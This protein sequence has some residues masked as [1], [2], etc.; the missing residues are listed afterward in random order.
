M[1][2]KYFMHILSLVTDNN[3]SSILEVINGP[4]REKICLW[5]FAKN[6]G[7]DQPAHL[8]S[9]ISAFVIRFL[10]SIICKLATGEISI[11]QMVSVAKYTGL[12]L[13]LSE[14]PKQGFLVTRPK[15]Y[16]A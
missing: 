2:N 6:T 8:R 12:K 14:T 5:E 1:V 7:A 11:F 9:L 16:K 3:P 4:R 13:A 10:E 15:L